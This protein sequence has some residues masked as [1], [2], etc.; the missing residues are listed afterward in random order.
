MLAILFL[1]SFTLKESTYSITLA[2]FNAPSS[3][4]EKLK[5]SNTSWVNG[6][7]G[8]V[9]MTFAYRDGVNEPMS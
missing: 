6:P 3:S 9:R 8:K 7:N 1:N 5:R 4:L 2:I